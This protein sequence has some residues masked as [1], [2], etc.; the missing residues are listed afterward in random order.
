MDV[1][2]KLQCQLWQTPEGETPQG[3]EDRFW[4]TGA[5][6]RQPDSPG[7]RLPSIS[8]LKVDTQGERL[9]D[10][11]SAPSHHPCLRKYFLSLGD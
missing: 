2:C 5:Q 1:V 10:C 7:L 8:S 6:G 9:V 4:A 11:P 3:S